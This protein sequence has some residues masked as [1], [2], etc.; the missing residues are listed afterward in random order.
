MVLTKELPIHEQFRM[1]F[2]LEAYNAFNHTQF[3]T[4]DTAARFD[5]A[6]KQVN[7]RFGEFLSSRPPRTLQF[8]LRFMF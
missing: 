7:A 5:A 1:Q 8:A 3:A 2:R 6:G 4:L